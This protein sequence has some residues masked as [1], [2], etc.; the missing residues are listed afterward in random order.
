M[1]TKQARSKALGAFTI[2]PLVLCLSATTARAQHELD[3]FD[4]DQDA[5]RSVADPKKWKEGRVALPPW[6]KDADL[7]EVEPERVAGSFRY[8][9][10]GA[11]LSV[12]SRDAIV[13]YSLVIEDAKGHRN[14]SF[15]GIRCTL[16]GHYRVYAYGVSGSFNRVDGT[17]WQIVPVRGSLAYLEDFFANR[18]C[19]PRGLRSKSK[20]DILRALND[21]GSADDS[22]FFLAD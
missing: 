8:F 2:L 11:H 16:H 22:A 3:V 18:F 19:V 21:R 4:T 10:D 9:I 14:V 6:P 15:E 1:I 5:P 7:I 17:E 12:D 20:K 13:R